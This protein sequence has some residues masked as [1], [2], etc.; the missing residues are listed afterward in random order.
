LRTKPVFLFILTIFIISAC[1]GDA[2][3]PDAIGTLEPVLAEYA[4]MTN[5]LGAEAAA[6]G[7][8]V[9]HDFCE[10]CHGPQGHGDGPAGQ[11]LDPKP[12]DLAA[13]QAVAGDDYL[14]W[15]IAEGKPGSSMVGWRGILSDEQI[16]QAIVFIRTLE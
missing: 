6:D 12:K 4:G 13:L 3:A 15:R 10:T 1:T 9:F 8:D 11:S 14:F 7:A 2:D 16:W 5:P